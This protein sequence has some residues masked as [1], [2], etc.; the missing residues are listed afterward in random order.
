MVFPLQHMCVCYSVCVRGLG[1]TWQVLPSIK[2]H[3]KPREEK[4]SNSCLCFFF[5]FADLFL[6]RF[7][8]MACTT[9]PLVKLMGN[10]VYL[11]SF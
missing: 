4:D 5:S 9:H 2:S 3:Q 8:G 6:L 11:L 7:A 1:I 10:S